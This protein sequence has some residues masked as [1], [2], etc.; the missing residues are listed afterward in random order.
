MIC[1]QCFKQY[2]VPDGKKIK[3]RFAYNKYCSKHCD[4]VARKGYV[5]K[6]N[7]TIEGAQVYN[8]ILQNGQLRAEQKLAM[9]VLKLA[10]QD[11]EVYMPQWPQL[12]YES[13]IALASALKL[14]FCDSQ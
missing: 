12:V 6:R 5:P 11:I 4:Y 14:M 8:D 10:K 9:T 2:K 3:I 1:G 13:R 7:A